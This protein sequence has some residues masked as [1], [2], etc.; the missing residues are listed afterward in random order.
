LLAFAFLAHGLLFLFPP[1]NMVE[2]MNEVVSPGFR[3]FLGVTEVL[4]HSDLRCRVSRASCPGSSP[5]PPR[6]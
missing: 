4:P 6:G 3:I 2:L 1:A 5:A